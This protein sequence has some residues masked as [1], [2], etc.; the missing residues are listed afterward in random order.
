M[1]HQPF[2]SPVSSDFQRRSRKAGARLIH[3]VGVI[4]L[5]GIIFHLSPPVLSQPGNC[6]VLTRVLEPHKRVYS[7]ADPRCDPTRRFVDTVQVNIPQPDFYRLRF[8]LRYTQEIEGAQLNETFYVVVR[9]VPSGKNI[10]PIDANLSATQIDSLDSNGDPVSLKVVLDDNA[11]VSPD[12]LRDAGVFQLD[13]GLNIIEISHYATISNRFPQFINTYPSNA[14]SDT[15]YEA[16]TPPILSG[17]LGGKYNAESIEFDSL[18]VQQVNCLN[19]DLSLALSA[20]RD[21]VFT[22][23]DAVNYAL[24]VRNLGPGAAFN[25]TV[26]DTIPEFV[27]PVAFNQQPTQ[28]GNNI[29]TW[30]IPFLDTDSSLTITYTGNI[31]VVP[32]DITTALRTGARVSAPSDTASGNDFAENTVIAIPRPILPK[33]YDVSLV[34]SA[35]RDT[36]FNTADAV[37]YELTVSNAGPH[38]ARSLTLV[39]SLP[40]FVT[41]ANFNITPSQIAGRWITWEFDSLAAGATLVLRYTGTIAVQPTDTTLSLT[42]FASVS[43]PNDTIPGNNTAQHTIVAVPRPVRYYDVSLEITASQDTVFTTGDALTYYLIA[44][45]LGPNTAFNLTVTDTLPPFISPAGFTPP[46]N[47]MHGQVLQWD[48]DSLGVNGTAIMLYTAEVNVSPADTTALLETRAGVQAPADT[49]L[50]NNLAQNRVVAVPRPVVHNF[51]LALVLLADRDSVFTTGEFVN[52]TLV[53]T[54]LGPNDARGIVLSDTLPEFVAPSNFN[55]APERFVDRLLEWEIASLSSS[56]SVTFTYTGAV[57]VVPPDVTQAL[58]TGARVSAPQDT[59][60]ANNFAENTVIAYPRPVPPPR[61]DLSLQVVASK[62]SVRTD[63]SVDFGLIIVNHGPNT[64]HQITL[65]DSLPPFITTSAFSHTPTQLADRV[66]QWSFD[67]LQV[68]TALQISYTGRFSLPPGLATHRLVTRGRVAAPNDSIPDNNFDQVMVI[69]IPEPPVR[70]NYDL[71][72]GLAASRDTVFTTS[73]SL[74]YTLTVRNLGPVTAFQITLSDTLPD[75]LTAEQIV[76][77]PQTIRGPVL[78]WALD[79]LETGGAA[80]FQYLA[81]VAVVPEDTT[82]ILDTR[83]A[84]GAAHDTLLSNNFARIAVVAVRR[85]PPVFALEIDKTASPANVAPG[86]LVTFTITA[87][88]RGNVPIPEYTITDVL[89]TQFDVNAITAY[90]PRPPDAV[91]GNRLSWQF[92]NLDVGSTQMVSFQVRAP[93]VSGDDVL[94]IANVVIATGSNLPPVGVRDSTRVIVARAPTLECYLDR[95]L[96]RPAVDPPLGIHFGLTAS[97]VVR[98]KIHDLSGTLIRILPEQTFGAGQHRLQWDGR[99]ENGMPAG[100]GVYIVT[101]ESDQFIGWKK[102]IVV[103]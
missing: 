43:A 70:G 50:T 100:S 101:F 55:V 13:A 3:F 82:A 4:F 1:L 54:N 28:L 95:N 81:R 57:D 71:S 99:A 65:V 45:N 16:L 92:T 27:T 87:R 36:V 64:A 56:A 93:Q 48:I 74:T 24:T 53:V 38:V 97:S 8:L 58:R 51:D 32:P 49:L 86:D 10:Y 52:Y 96:W 78:V 18:A 84:V 94:E 35:S 62:D 83:A 33:N 22:T 12:T 60:L 5:L 61:Y 9:H 72:L 40:P 42:N 6:I 69:G 102:V 77:A 103:R 25:A 66:L 29:A 44:S 63:E 20:D 30:Q 39:D 85:P 23:G 98:I 75:F 88:N 7:D 46:P 79:S 17:H 41:P 59:L 2:P 19:Y 76:P 14:P 80:V 21:T 37:Q 26:S 67:S 90:S 34:K 31:A 73:D 89:P 11:V 68:N 47:R 91:S 15:C